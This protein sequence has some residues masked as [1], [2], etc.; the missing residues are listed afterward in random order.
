VPTPLVAG[1]ASGS[2]LLVLAAAAATVLLMRRAQRRRRLTEGA[3]DDRIT[4]AWLEFTDASRLA[5]RPIPG[6]LAA[7]EAAT[8]AATL[9]PPPKPLLRKASPAGSGSEA[10]V[11]AE[12]PDSATAA[13]PLDDLV[14]G[15]NTVGF[16]PGAADEDQA[17][18]AG[19]QALAYAEALRRRRSWWRRAWWSVHPGPLRWHRDGRRPVR[20]GNSGR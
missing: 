4:G 5:G 11:A 8:F 16:A 1:G 7:T 18:R 19:E 20:A 6:H 15:L 9:P 2:A 13:P 3:P 14:A 12:P 17:R 10:A